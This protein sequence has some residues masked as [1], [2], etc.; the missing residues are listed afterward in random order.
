MPEKAQEITPLLRRARTAVAVCF[1][2]QGIS[3]AA[4]LTRIPALQRQYG[5]GDGALTVC[6]SLVP[7]I[8]GVGSVVSEKLAA[9]HGSRAVLRVAQPFIAL[10][11]V[12]VG[13]GEHLYTFLPALVVFGFAVGALDATMNMQ[14]VRLQRLYGRSIML[15]FHGVWSLGGIAGA[16]AAGLSAHYDVSL[17]WL[18][19][20]VAVVA[21]PIAYAAGLHYLHAEEV[22][23]QKTEAPKLPWKPL[24]PL[25]AVMAFAYVG[26]ASVSSWGA[27]YMEDVLDSAEDFATVP[28]I[29]Y[30]I[31]VLLGRAIGDWGV[32]RWGMVLVA[33][34]GALLAAA[35][36]A[37]VVIAP[38]RW[39]GL[40]GFVV[41][42]L[43][44]SVLVPQTFAAAA[45]LAPGDADTAVARLNI[46]NYV[47][48]LVGTPLVGA[49]GA[50]GSLRIGMIAP[51]LLVLAV[52]P[53]AK[54]FGVTKSADGEAAHVP[55]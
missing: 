44:L 10:S 46:F 38:D 36:F 21:I 45:R 35:G 12:A 41:L 14:G 22:Q 55:A 53:L 6:I 42:G 31:T 47:G 49:V 27:K 48:F 11:L 39:T 7:I 54:V 32:A 9:K 37:V 51:L 30:L 50:A 15:S 34:S 17:G 23:L 40:L 33:K 18:Y 20:A 28:Y 5:L 52:L 1:L 26:D 8:C 43:G 2:V 4:L 3:F 16:G 25:C 29:A 19:T 13:W 24:L